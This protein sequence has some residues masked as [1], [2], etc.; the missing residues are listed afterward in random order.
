MTTHPFLELQEVDSALDAVGHRRTRL[1]ELEAHRRD[2]TAVAEVHSA[3]ASAQARIDAAAATIAAAEQVAGE[4]TSKRT[5][6][7]AQ[8]KT[9]IAPREAEALMSQIATLNTQRG[10]SDDTE[11]AALDE[12][13]A[14]EADLAAHAARL[15]AVEAALAASTAAL[16]AANT[17]LDGEA[18]SLAERREA[19]VQTTPP[20]ELARY[21]RVRAQ[22]GGVGVA[23]LEGTHCSGCHMDLSPKELDV[24]RK[25]PP[26]ELGECPQCGRM[27]V[28]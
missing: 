14:A 20:S 11:L 16:A 25:V 13:A 24:L 4:L 27:L 7:E 26:D 18:A 1:A 23:H 22:F 19:L 5:R 6:L 3:M 17:A 2:A 12:Q 9:V 21:E 10:E 28:R 8:L 15:P